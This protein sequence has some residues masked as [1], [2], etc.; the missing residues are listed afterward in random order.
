AFQRPRCAAY[1]KFSRPGSGY[2]L[3]GVFV[4]VPTNDGQDGKTETPRV[5]VTGAG[6]CVFRARDMEAAL[7]QRFAPEAIAGITVPEGELVTD[8]HASAAYRA[9]LV[10]VMAQRAVA[11]ALA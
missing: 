5:A 2:A 7:A 9:H 11:A 10:T 1:V 8:L 6:P 3:A 4:A